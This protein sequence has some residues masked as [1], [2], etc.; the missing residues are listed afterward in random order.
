MDLKQLEYFV[1]VAELG[2]FT[3]AAAVLRVAQ[4]ALSRQIQQLEASLRVRLLTRNGRGVVPTD[5][6]RRFLDHSRGILRQVA[7]AREEIEETRGAKVGRVAIGMPATMAA[8]LTVPLVK[9]FRREFP[10]A[11]ISVLQGRSTTL[12]EWLVSGRI[13]V[14]VLYNAP[15]SPLVA[16]TPLLTEEL[17]L[18]QRAGLSSGKGSV[19]VAA[20]AEIPLIL[21]SRPNT[22]RTMV[23]TELAR[24]GLQP[25]V[26][27]EIDNVP[28]I[29][30]LVGDGFGSAVLSPRAVRD[31]ATS[32]ALSVRP[33]V[34]PVLSVELSISVSAR[35][36]SSPILDAAEALIR[37]LSQSVL[38]VP[39]EPRRTGRK[40]RSRQ[41]AD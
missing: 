18:V 16:T 23:D 11:A 20:L 6:G 7:R 13:D 21:P 4:P 30:D 29:I 2:S 25:A 40:A 41:V 24:L 36:P 17:V 28:N 33:I 19:P 27:L 38:R 37:E 14:A 39:D 1:R 22:T 5:A 9:T 12:Q 31:A 8:S 10:K 15:F 3:K 26:A 34:D 32:K 35:R